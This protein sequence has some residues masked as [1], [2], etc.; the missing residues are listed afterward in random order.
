MEISMRLIHTCLRVL[1]EKRSIAFYEALGFRE[2]KRERIGDEAINIHLGLPVD[3]AEPSL[4][5]TVN[6]GRTEPYVVGNGFGHIAVTAPNLDEFL[7]HL[8][9]KGIFPRK[10]PASGTMGG[11]RICFLDDPDGYPVELVG[12]NVRV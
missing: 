6:L 11:T 10:P 4:E 9:E 12:R 7:K 5:L 1:D 3:G 2:V 8:A